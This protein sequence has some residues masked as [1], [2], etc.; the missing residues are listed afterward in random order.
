MKPCPPQPR[1][2]DQPPPPPQQLLLLLYWCRYH[3]HHH[4]SCCCC[5]CT[6]VATTNLSPQLQLLLY[7]EREVREPETKCQRRNRERELRKLKTKYQTRHRE[8]EV[9]IKKSNV[10]ERLFGN[11]EGQEEHHQKSKKIRQ[12]TTPLPSTLSDALQ[13]DRGEEE[14]MD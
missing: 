8:R 9:R 10:R 14:E 12:G 11:Q 1:Y 4:Y 6:G 3:Q 2:K 7:R 5:C 13:G